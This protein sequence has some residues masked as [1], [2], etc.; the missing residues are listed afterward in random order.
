MSGRDA[1][2]AGD[3]LTLPELRGLRRTSRPR[4]AGL[5]V[6]AWNY[7]LEHHLLV[8]VPCWRLPDAHALLLAKG[9]GPSM[10]VA[11]GYLDVIRRATTVRSAS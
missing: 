1:L 5:V 3:L 8:F 9:H 4:G 10:E 2:T 11:P 6:H 7:H